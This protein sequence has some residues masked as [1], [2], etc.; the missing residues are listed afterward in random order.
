MRIGV[1]GAGA[2]GTALACVEAAAGREV[3]LWGRDKAAMAA[4]AEAR[5][6]SVRLAGVG[7]PDGLRPVAEIAALDDCAILLMVLP[8]QAT[9]GFLAEHGG[10]LPEVP[11]VFCAKGLS[12]GISAAS[13]RSAARRCRAGRWRC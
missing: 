12:R 2:F 6:N 4:M 11:V 3:V 8:A 13:R 7:L 9:A 5:E 10:A 1:I